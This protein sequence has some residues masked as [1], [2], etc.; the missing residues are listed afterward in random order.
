MI[1]KFLTSV[2]LFIYG[3]FCTQEINKIEFRHSNAIILFKLVDIVFQPIK[4]H[5][6]GKVRVQVKKD[7]DEK[8][9]YRISKEKFDEINRAV[10]K[11]QYDTV[12]VKNNLLDGSSSD[13][14]LYDNLDHEKH[15]FATGLD[16]KSQTN[17]NQKDFWYA[18][19][20]IMNAARLKMEDL[21][22]YR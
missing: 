3:L 20:L 16:K 11:I 1:R 19:K 22:G 17:I 15:F 10:L 7:R 12:A 5:K 8:Y 9:T 21:I 14:T 13:I 4:N 6:K 18:T 2:L